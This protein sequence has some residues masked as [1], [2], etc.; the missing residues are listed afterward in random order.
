MP[1][2]ITAIR[3]RAASA[4]A[5]PAT[6]PA[7]EP[8][9]V[10]EPEPVKP[11]YDFSSVTSIQKIVNKDSRLDETYK[12]SDLVIADVTKDYDEYLRQEAADALKMMFDA[13]AADGTQLLLIDGYRSYSEQ[14]SLY[15][16]YLERYGSSTVAT[17]DAHPGASEHQ[18]GLAVDLGDLKRSC[19]L[20][21]CFVD[22]SAYSWL[23]DNA[24]KYGWIE[25]YPYGKTNI[26]G[27][28]FSPWHYRYVGTDLARDLY[29]SGLTLEEYTWK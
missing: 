17:M 27:I 11:E 19:N 24:W 7:S 14:R 20:R 1:E 16:T 2:I 29:E 9:P 5:E 25:R 21:S 22:T 4:A 6:E 26:T 12:P 10:P 28:N 23:K 13:A 8:E 18:L 15:Y 3:N